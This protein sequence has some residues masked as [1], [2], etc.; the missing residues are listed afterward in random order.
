[1]DILHPRRRR[2]AGQ[3]FRGEQHQP[4]VELCGREHGP[5]EDPEHERC[6]ND[7][8]RAVHL[9]NQMCLR[10]QSVSLRGGLLV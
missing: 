9:Q 4:A 2:P 1:M 10:I 8:F 5:R 7:R 3:P 6:D